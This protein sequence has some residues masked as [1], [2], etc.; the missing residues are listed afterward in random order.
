[1]RGL[2]P[3]QLQAL[4][5][6]IDT[7]SFSAAATRRGLSQPAVSLQ[8]RQLERRFGVRLIERVGR[9]A[10]P[11]AAGEELL[12][13]IRGIDEAVT[14]ASEAM[15]EHRREIIGRVRLGT[16]ATACI[17]LLPKILGELRRRL[18]ALEI[19]VA[20]GN[21]PQILKQVEDNILDV[22]LVTLPARGAM[23]EVIPVMADEQVAVFAAGSRP[24]RVVTPEILAQRPL[25]LY[26]PGGNAR[27]VF[28]DWFA[29]SGRP[30]KP[31]MALGSVEAIKELVAA[32]L[33]CAVLPRLAVTGRG[34]SKRLV[35]RSLEPRLYRTLGVV[36]RRDKPLTRGLRMVVEA[37]SLAGGVRARRVL[38]Q[39]RHVIAAEAGLARGFRNTGGAP[40][41]RLR[42]RR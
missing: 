20:T 6:V 42:N 1:M 14:R 40:P 21:T 41:A 26:E 2:N 39:E 24:P 4:A 30:L 32:G 17:Y 31:V 11:T 15:A 36:L 10:T 34:A 7:G 19:V 29:R 23:F 3:D 22:A 13:H 37:L 12:R 38:E 28:D 35:V 5:D 25:V 9:R 8:I 33:G 16:G 27:Q 18:P